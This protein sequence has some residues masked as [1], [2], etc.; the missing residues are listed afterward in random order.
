VAPTYSVPF[1]RNALVM[2]A[3]AAVG[4]IGSF[5]GLTDHWEESICLFHAMFGGQVNP[6][7]LDNGT[8]YIR[9]FTCLM[10]HTCARY[11]VA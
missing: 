5:I 6:H 11:I 7:E 10:H 1:H 8:S 4:N 2:A 3:A 9:Q